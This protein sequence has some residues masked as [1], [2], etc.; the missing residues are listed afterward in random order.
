MVIASS[1]LACVT[2][3]I[4][5]VN[6]KGTI[7]QQDDNTYIWIIP[8]VGSLYHLDH[9]GFVKVTSTSFAYPKTRAQLYP[10]ALVIEVKSNDSEFIY[11]KED[12]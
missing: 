1:S 9:Y 8:P 3:K 12:M 11:S 4:L 5:F 10:E 7:V 2:M 6:R